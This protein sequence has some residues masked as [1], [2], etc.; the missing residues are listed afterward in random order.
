MC[1]ICVCFQ[2]VA[3]IREHIWHNALLMGYSMRLALT[4]VRSLSSSN[5]LELININVYYDDISGPRISEKRNKY[6]DLT[7]ERNM[8]MTVIPIVIGARGT[9]TNGLVKELKE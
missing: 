2:L 5:F 4:L 8:K 7:R 6:L 9:I 1:Y 3:F